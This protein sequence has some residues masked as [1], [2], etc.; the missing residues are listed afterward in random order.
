MPKMSGWEVGKALKELDPKIPV[1]MITGWGM[2]LDRGKMSESG[3]DLI[4]SKPFN[5]DQVSEL[6]YE[7]MELK[8]KM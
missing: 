1:V 3:I 4:I 2:E 8:N 7:A 6:V 5:F